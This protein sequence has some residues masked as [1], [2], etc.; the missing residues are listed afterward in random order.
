VSDTA[1][2]AQEQ[3]STADRVTAVPVHQPT[4]TAAFAAA[5][6]DHVRWGPVLAGLCAALSILATLEVLGLAMVLSSYATGYPPTNFVR[7]AAFWSAGSAA[8]AFLIGGWLAARTAA[9]RGRG[10][11]LFHG[12]MVWLVAVP[13]VFGLLGAAGGAALWNVTPDEA[14]RRAASQRAHLARLAGVAPE[15]QQVAEESSA[16]A[17]EVA[18]TRAPASP[19]RVAWNVFT[20]LVFTLAAAGLGGLAGAHV[21]PR[22]R[23][24]P[25]DD[26]GTW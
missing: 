2:G 22:V 26:T 18:V 7:S 10:S 11:G 9:T 6:R 19:G 24:A 5:P 1:D 23:P 14:A 16:A 4:A 8:A 17:T 20:A 15:T 12:V 25:D 21:P 3:P 13:L